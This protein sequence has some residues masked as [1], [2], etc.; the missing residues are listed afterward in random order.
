[1][2]EN[3][4][5]DL[6]FG[7]VYRQVL[8]EAWLPEGSDQWMRLGKSRRGRRPTQQGLGANSPT[9]SQAQV[10]LCFQ[11]CAS[12]WRQLPL[13]YPAGHPCEGIPGK[14]FWWQQKQE[15]GVMCSYYDHYMRYCMFNCLKIGCPPEDIVCYAWDPDSTQETTYPLWSP[16]YVIGGISPFQWTVNDPPFRLFYTITSTR[17]NSIASRDDKCGIATITVTDYCGRTVQGVVTTPGVPWP[18]LPPTWSV[19]NPEEMNQDSSIEISVVD[20]STP[21]KWGIS[22]TGFTLA[23]AETDGRTNTLIASPTA[24]GPAQITFT[25]CLY[26]YGTGIVRSNVGNWIFQ[27]TY[28]SDRVAPVYCRE[29]NAGPAKEL[30]VGYM[31]WTFAGHNRMCAASQHVWPAGLGECTP[32]CSP[33][34]C[35]GVAGPCVV[36]ANCWGCPPCEV[37]DEACDE[38]CHPDGTFAWYAVSCYKFQC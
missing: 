36:T 3:P 37:V 21:V 26:N 38:P 11:M 27:G 12:N 30:I 8:Q 20:G 23:H 4:G 32:P 24:C 22:G 9:I 13:V 15:R 34:D 17:N 33:H 10:R 2:Y 31:K 28:Y 5:D 16:I 1:M 14:E 6:Y 18:Y 19:D 7:E 29:F 35:A 25:D